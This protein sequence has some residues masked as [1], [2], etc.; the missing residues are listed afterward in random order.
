MSTT[1]PV[2]WTTWP[3][4]AGVACGWG[5][6]AGGMCFVPQW[7]GGGVLW[8]FGGRGDRH[9]VAWP[10]PDRR[11]VGCVRAASLARLS[12]GGDLDHFARDV[13]LTN[14]V[15][16]EGEVLDQFLGIVG[17][18]LHR[19]HPARLLRRLRLEHRLED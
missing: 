2:I 18:V 1:G 12:A 9:D 13:R 5:G 3:V 6:V 8:V 10:S 14:L 17:R 19:D 11:S 16:G 15:V 4:A 7:V